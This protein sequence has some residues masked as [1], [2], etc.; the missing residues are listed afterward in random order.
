MQNFWAEHIKLIIKA[1]FNN[2][3]LWVRLEK[4]LNIVKGFKN[5]LF[6]SPL[7]MDIKKLKPTIKC[8]MCKK[9]FQQ[10]IFLCETGHSICGHCKQKNRQC[11]S[12]KKSLGD[13][14][15]YTLESIL[16]T[17]SY[18]C[19]ICKL[20][21]KLEFFLN[22]EEECGWKCILCNEKQIKD[23]NFIIRHLTTEHNVY[24]EDYD[25]KFK[26]LLKEEVRFYGINF[27][28]GKILVKIQ[29]ASKKKYD[30]VIMNYTEVGKAH[31]SVVINGRT[32]VFNLGPN[33][34]KRICIKN[35]VEGLMILFE[36][37]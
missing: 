11:S 23:Y 17:Q 15:N 31:G 25:K 18:H 29:K 5:E 6:V 32:R 33:E 9:A 28:E 7:K 16:Q 34:I 2:K 3:L 21:I 12:C 27:G 30:F 22:H 26:L 20:D 4:Y 35:F 1:V 24:F 8:A 13:W 10:E 37:K 14:R 19:C 36:F